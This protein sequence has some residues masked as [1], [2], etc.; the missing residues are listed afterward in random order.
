MYF[1]R[2]QDKDSAQPSLKSTTGE[3]SV[4]TL[5]S[6]TIGWK[7]TSKFSNTAELQTLQSYRGIRN[8]NKRTPLLGRPAFPI[9]V[10]QST[11]NPPLPQFLSDVLNCTLFQMLNPCDKLE[12]LPPLPLCVLCAWERKRD[13]GSVSHNLT[14]IRISWQKV[15]LHLLTEE[16]LP[17]C[18]ALGLQLPAGRWFLGKGLCH[19]KPASCDGIHSPIQ[20]D[21]FKVCYK[22]A[23]SAVWI[24][25]LA[26]EYL[27]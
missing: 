6:A 3:H 22:R 14:T 13:L 26:L 8:E 4:S 19:L 23:H 25:D 2:K 9:A 11:K 27:S 15:K 10:L 5:R 7:I 21:V 1:H 12:H 24:L 20:T 16:L 17:T 18:W